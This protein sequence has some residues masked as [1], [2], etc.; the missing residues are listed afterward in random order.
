MLLRFCFLGSGLRLFALNFGD[1][2]LQRTAFLDGTDHGSG[3]GDAH[4]LLSHEILYVQSCIH[5]LATD[6]IGGS[7][8]LPHW[9]L[10]HEAKLK[11]TD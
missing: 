11:G 2:L 4:S 6:L 10:I 7:E 1:G 3:I 9:G 5:N 8:N